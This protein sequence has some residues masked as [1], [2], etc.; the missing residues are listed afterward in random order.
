MGVYVYCLKEDYRHQSQIKG[1][2]FENDWM[3]LDLDGTV[4]VK[5]TNQQG[6]AWDGCT[7]KIK[8]NDV[9][10]GT[11][12]G[13]LNFVTGQAKTHYASLIHDV[14]YQFS[15][16]LRPF[17]RRKEADREFYL[18]LKDH[19]FKFARFYYLAVRLFGWPSW[20]KK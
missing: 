20:Y 10:F 19:Q 15:R 6:Y 17:I 12:E 7:P 16:Q 13:V 11:P 14:F 18:I 3:K 4:T 1:R 5:G 9:Y 8:I 2:Q